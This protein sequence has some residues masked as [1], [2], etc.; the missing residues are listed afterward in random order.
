LV[1]T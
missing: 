1:T